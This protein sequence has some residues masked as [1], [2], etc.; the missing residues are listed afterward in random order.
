[1]IP[2]AINKRGEEKRGM[3]KGRTGE[4]EREGG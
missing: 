3:G 2:V 1:M 4:R